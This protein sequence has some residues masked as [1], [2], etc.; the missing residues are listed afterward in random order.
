MSTT[1]KRWADIRSKGK[2]SERIARI[3][4]E[5]EE[6]LLEMDLRAMRE[7]LGKSQA[8]VA[9]A[10]K[11]SQSEVS[12]LERREDYRLSTLRRVVEALGGELEVIANFGDRRIRL[13]GAG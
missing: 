6:E 11:M 9:D 8:E 7:L 10:V 5:V 2:S 12:R 4:R 13:R 1:Y 3:T